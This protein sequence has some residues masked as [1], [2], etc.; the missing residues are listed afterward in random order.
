MMRIDRSKDRSII[1][2]SII[3]NVDKKKVDRK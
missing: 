1:D 2:L 3:I